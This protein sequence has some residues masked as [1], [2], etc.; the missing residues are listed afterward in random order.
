MDQTIDLGQLREAFLQASESDTPR[1]IAVVF[2]V[3]LLLAVLLLVRRRRLR[4][5]YT[6]IWVAVSVVITL[7]ALR[8]DLLVGL[9]RAVGGWTVSSTL[10]FLGEVFLLLI[11]LQYAVRLSRHGDRIK[12][13]AQE[14][15]L[16]RARVDRLSGL[17]ARERDRPLAPGAPR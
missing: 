14:A 11:C 9:T 5:E 2:S 10:F 17:A 4:E 1:V 8:L 7:V 12:D 15:A 16:M 3:L 6:P 13:L